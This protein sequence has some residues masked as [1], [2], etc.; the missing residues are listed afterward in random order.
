MQA[1]SHRRLSTRQ[2]RHNS[3]FHRDLH[4][5]SRRRYLGRAHLKYTGT[6]MKVHQKAE[7]WGSQG[8]FAGQ[9]SGWGLRSQASGVGGF[10]VG[11]RLGDF[12][13]RHQASG[14]FAARRQASGKLRQSASGWETSQR[15]IRRQG[16]RSRRQAS[17]ASR[18]ASGWETSQRGIRRQGLRSRRQASGKLRQSASGWETSQRG[19][20]RQG[21]SQPGVRRRGS[22]ASRHQAGR[23]RREASGVRGLPS[24]A[25]RYSPA[26]RTTVRPGAGIALL[27]A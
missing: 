15:G 18:S 27:A 7:E 26:C 25:R 23:L 12:A 6:P 8:G 17:G 10:A 24:V 5:E 21:T 9:A 13:E 16:L 20:R 19:I 14:D 3:L 11:I 4:S 22:F 1:H 2:L